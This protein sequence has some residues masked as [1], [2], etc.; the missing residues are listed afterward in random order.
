MFICF[1]YINFYIHLGAHQNYM[2]LKKIKINSNLTWRKYYKIITDV[3]N[4]NGRKQL[5]AHWQQQP[6]LL[7]ARQALVVGC[8]YYFAGVFKIRRWYSSVD[9]ATW[10]DRVP[11][12][13]TNFIFVFFFG[14]N[15]FT[16]LETA[17][18]VPASA[19][20]P[21]TF[22]LKYEKGS[23]YTYAIKV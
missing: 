14:V 23:N 16:P 4:T 2:Y 7:P 20:W 3:E 17:R 6:L 10:L 12:E 19:I 13:H 9:G 15:T 22:R 18:S 5:V 1:G 8:L 11:L 21:C